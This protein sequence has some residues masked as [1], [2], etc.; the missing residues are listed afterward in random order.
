MSQAGSTT[1]ITRRQGDRADGGDGDRGR[2]RMRTKLLRPLLM[3][4][5][6]GVIISV[7]AL[8]WL[9]T[10]GTVYVTDTYIRAR[11]VELSTDVPGLVQ[12]VAVHDNEHVK[13]GQV[14][15]RLDPSRLTVAIT[16]TEAE[17]AEVK[18]GVTGYKHSYDAQL[19]HIKQQ[20]AIVD[21]DK[22]SYQRYA[23]LV[24][25]GGVTRSQYDNAKYALQGEQAK[26]AAIR[27]QADVGLAK[28]FGD[29]RIKLEDTPQYK[30]A[31]AALEQAQ[32]NYMHSVIRA[33]FSGVVTDTD[34]LNP[35]MYLPAGTVAFPLVSQRDIWVRSQPK[36]TQLTSVRKGDKVDIHVDAYPGKVWHGVVQTISPASASS[37]SLLPPQNSSGNW[38]KVVQRVPLRVK[39]D[40]GP[41]RLTLRNGMSA[42]IIIHT[43]Q[44]RRAVQP[45]FLSRRWSDTLH[46]GEN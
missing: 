42:E 31:R 46:R 37:F 1:R 21:N 25:S 12:S 29:P 39:I 18:Q 33:P 23:R 45:R 24:K 15:V 22:L 14:L 27:D 10:S 28:L 32:L 20:E 35:G 38:V 26:L 7:A 30:A 13:K 40:S 2:S 19:A 34:T 43:D 41:K 11:W 6:V 36:E 3:I 9:L 5:G 44:Q 4:G 8:Y 17:L 16:R